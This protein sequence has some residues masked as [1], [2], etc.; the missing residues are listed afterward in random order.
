MKVLYPLLEKL[1]ESHSSI[2][3]SAL[4][5][6]RKIASLHGK[7]GINDLLTSNVDYLVDAINFKMKYPYTVRYE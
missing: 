3:Q 7:N 1:G 5:T 6:L 2:S 4:V